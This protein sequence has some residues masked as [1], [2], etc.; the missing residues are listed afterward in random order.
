MTSCGSPP[1][2]RELKLPNGDQ[3]EGD[4]NGDG[5]ATP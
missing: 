2:R 3:A 1:S 4:E 5:L